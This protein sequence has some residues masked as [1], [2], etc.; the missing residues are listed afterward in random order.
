[1]DT[2]DTLEEAVLLQKDLQEEDQEWLTQTTLPE[3]KQVELADL[4]YTELQAAEAAEAVA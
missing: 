1:V 2:Q 3:D 4:V